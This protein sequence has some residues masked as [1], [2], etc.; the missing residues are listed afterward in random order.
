MTSNK[1]L[2]IGAGQDIIPLM[3]F[4]DCN[5]FVFV[6]TLPRS[7]F[8]KGSTFRPCYYRPNFVPELIQRCQEFDFEYISAVTM[9]PEYYKQI[10][11]PGQLLYYWGHTFDFV[12]PTLLLFMNKK[13]CQVLKYYVSTQLKFNANSIGSL[14]VDIFQCD[15]LIVSGHHPQEELALYIEKPMKF[16]GYTSTVFKHL[17]EPSFLTTP[18]FSEY[19][20]EFFVCL[21]SNGHRFRVN[22][23]AKLGELVYEHHRHLAM[24]RTVAEA[25]AKDRG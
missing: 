4:A 24:G 6:D 25:M 7:E 2:Y 1:I 11:T 23:F 5:E 12:N 18:T 20:K 14:K 8:D 3:H 19:V 15:G 22:D 13:T 21:R 16:Y 9:D 17:E 10:F